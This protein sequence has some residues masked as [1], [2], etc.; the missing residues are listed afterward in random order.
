[1][2]NNE[3]SENMENNITSTNFDNQK[4]SNSQLNDN[5]YKSVVENNDSKIEN[6]LETEKKE[7]TEEVSDPEIVFNELKSIK[8]SNGKI[9][10]KILSRIR[11]GYKANYKGLS[12]FLPYPQFAIVKNLDEETLNSEIGKEYEVKVIEL[13]ED[14]SKKHKTVVVSRKELLEE[15]FWN[16]IKIGDIVEGPV[17]SIASFGIFIDLGGNEGL[18][19]IS[20]LSNKRIEDTKSFAKKGDIIKAK[21]I[22]IDRENNRIGL[23]AKEFAESPWNNI[24]NKF[25][26]SQK[27]KGI[28]RR[29]VDFGAYLEI[30]P[31]V[32]ALL[33]N[34]ELSWTKRIKSVSEIAKINDELEVVINSINPE[35]QTMSVSLREIQ[36]NPWPKL[37]E[38]YTL[39]SE[40][41]GIV[42][43]VTSMGCLLTL[44]DEV[45]CFMPRSKMRDVLKG[46]KIPYVVGNE[47][48]VAIAD[49]DPN[50]ESII[51]K[52][53]IIKEEYP[54]EI[55]LKE[56]Q[57]K[58]K[59]PKQEQK[60]KSN[61]RDIKEKKEE[62]LSANAV[63]LGDMLSS[64]VLEKLFKN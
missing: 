49:I 5:Q 61:Q 63:T 43:E 29:I 48:K 20:R 38:K 27:V 55:P 4:D 2:T 21:V 30:E 64:N 15:E 46:K 14:D 37:A 13:A 25:K 34:A 45:D 44:N 16:K 53:V 42:K 59:L 10:I 24:N 12:V 1:M 3:I 11:G 35:K 51:L 36:E 56:K 18:I 60:F 9:K 31:G 23:S 54:D 6:N 57:Y 19:H 58:E 39:D 41:N 33:R 62:K 7:I 40:H 32:D 17:T 8:E 22:E 26:V 52:P 28:V 47:V 50:K